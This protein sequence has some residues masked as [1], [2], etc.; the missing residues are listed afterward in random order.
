MEIFYLLAKQ[1]TSDKMHFLLILSKSNLYESLL[2]KQITELK[3]LCMNMQFSN[4]QIE[5]SSPHC[6]YEEFFYAKPF[7]S[8]QS[9]KKQELHG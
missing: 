4:T 2:Q 5:L 3:D 9:E 8:D 7:Y 1:Q 6:T